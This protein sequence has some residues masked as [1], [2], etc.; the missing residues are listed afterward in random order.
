MSV[1]QRQSF[2]GGLLA[3]SGMTPGRGWKDLREARRE[4]EQQFALKT[5][6]E[7]EIYLNRLS[8]AYYTAICTNAPD[9]DEDVS[10]Q[11]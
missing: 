9:I 8:L 11:K 3:H 10:Q 4:F 1:A 2:K 5:S 6:E 7:R